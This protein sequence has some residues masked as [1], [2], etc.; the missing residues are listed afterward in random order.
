MKY[1]PFASL[2]STRYVKTLKAAR[3]ATKLGI[4][5][6]YITLAIAGLFYFSSNGSTTILNV[7]Q[8]LTNGVITSFALIGS[9]CLMALL[10]AF[11]SDQE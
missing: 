1:S 9:G 10:I 5:G 6:F 8:I 2:T 4:I 7:N 3:L 11:N